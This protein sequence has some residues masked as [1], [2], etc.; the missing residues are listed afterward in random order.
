MFSHFDSFIKLLQLLPFRQKTAWAEAHPTKLNPA[1][2]MAGLNT[3]KNR[4]DRKS[5]HPTLWIPAFA[6]MT[7]RIWHLAKVLRRL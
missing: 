3:K 1:I 2:V 5:V 4:V 7:S 6:G